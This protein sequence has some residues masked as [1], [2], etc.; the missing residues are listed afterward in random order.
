M[1]VLVTGSTQGI[2]LGVAKD[3][4]RCGHEVIVHCSRDIAKAE[5]VRDEIG[6]SLAVT[7]DLADM[8]DVRSLHGKTGDVDI[9]ILNASVQY[10][11]KWDEVT[12]ETYDKQ[13]DVNVKSTLFLI[14]DYIGAMKEKRFGRIVTLGTVNQ[15]R[16]HMELQIYSATK[17]AVTSLIKGI[18]KDVAKYGI[19][20][21][22]VSPGAIATP[23]NAEVYDDDAKRQSVE[24]AIPLGRFGSVDDCV[25]MIRLLCSDE[26]AYITGTDII[27][28]GGLML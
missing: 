6:A 10:K 16:R 26:G 17:C 21:N 1:R 13:F 15:Y 18:A 22:S 2:G 12:E 20:V 14:Q 9:L 8:N 28:D 24:S 19:T 25:G 23:R 27:V 4:V 7:A 11:E 3:F 5:R